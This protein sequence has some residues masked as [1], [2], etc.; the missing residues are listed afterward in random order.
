MQAE[1]LDDTSMRPYNSSNMLERRLHHRQK[2]MVKGKM[3]IDGCQFRIEMRDMSK[4]GA[5]LMLFSACGFLKAGKLV[6]LCLMW[7]YKTSSNDLCVKA[8]IVRV[9]K[10]EVGIHF[11]HVATS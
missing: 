11:S 5:K 9:N 10:Q 1:T 2:T 8:T 6:E 3:M 7:P 4:G